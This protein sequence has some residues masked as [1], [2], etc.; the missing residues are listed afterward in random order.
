[1]QLLPDEE[2]F[3]SYVARA[4]ERKACRYAW[5]SMGS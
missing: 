5:E 4:R 2:P 1:M 3:Q